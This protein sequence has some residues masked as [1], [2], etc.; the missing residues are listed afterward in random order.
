MSLPPVFDIDALIA[1]ISDEQPSG[2]YL[3]ESDFTRLQA[4][5]DARTTA[6][7]NERRELE[8]ASFTDADRA[9]MHAEDL[10]VDPP[11]WKLVR[12]LCVEILT[13]HS[14]DLWVASWLIEA[15]ARLDGFAGLRDAFAVL[16][17]IV[18][19][20]WET[21]HPPRDEDDDFLDTIS[22]L[23]SL[24][25]ETGTGTLV[26]P[27]KLLALLP[28]SQHE[29][30]SW[31]A[32]DAKGKMDAPTEAEFLSAA[33]Q[34]DQ[35][36]LRSYGET[37]TETIAAFDQM[38]RVV[39][40]KLRESGCDEQTP[41]SSD[42]RKALQSCELTFTQIT[43]DVLAGGASGGDDSAGDGVIGS[44][45]G[46]A[47]AGASAG[48]GL[49]IGAAQV[50]NREDAFRLLLRAS[51]FFR[52]TEPHSPVSYMLQQAVRFG[53]MELPELLQE[54]IR[55]EDV[56]ARFAER[57]GIEIKSESEYDS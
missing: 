50:N 46:V 19:A 15:S 57:T 44:G 30:F 28:G 16:A 9:V 48:A 37:I 10:Q 54:L 56:L 35:S 8:L 12:K 17:G 22:Q 41:P 11:D 20:Y 53:R 40:A 6:M 39:E 13:H 38:I 26:F 29:E 33:R 3:K 18:E 36:E 51:E 45:L 43:R 5:K 14:K 4:A 31:A 27:V 42:I 25:G 52:K 23:A 55:D 49:S 21:I 47:G 34:I 7:S 32:Y 24:N 1:P 2:P